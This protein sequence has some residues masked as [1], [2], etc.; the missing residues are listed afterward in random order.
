MKELRISYKK[1]IR[2]VDKILENIF[3]IGFE[4]N[5][6]AFNNAVICL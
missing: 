3:K 6:E 1:R 2:V 4:I 5:Y